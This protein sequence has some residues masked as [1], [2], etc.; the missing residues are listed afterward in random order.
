MPIRAKLSPMKYA[1]G[2]AAI[3]IFAAGAYC[4]LRILAFKQMLDAFAKDIRG[5]DGPGDS[6]NAERRAASDANGR[7]AHAS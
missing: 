6:P 3:L 4:G 1:I 5:V 2:T 7:D